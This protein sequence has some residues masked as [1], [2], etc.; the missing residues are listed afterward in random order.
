M[1]RVGRPHSNRLDVLERTVVVLRA[2]PDLAAHPE[3][4]RARVRA[5]GR[6][7]RRILKALR[8]MQ[9]IDLPAPKVGR[10]KNPVLNPPDGLRDEDA[11]S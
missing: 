7:V 2:E 5:R 6:D 10:P 4:L 8:A 1:S 3:L 11:A 9:G